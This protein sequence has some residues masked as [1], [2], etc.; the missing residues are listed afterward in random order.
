M[1]SVVELQ[2]NGHSLGPR[3][4]SVKHPLVLCHGFI[5]KR[6]DVA[7]VK[8]KKIDVQTVFRSR[9][10]FTPPFTVRVPE[11]HALLG[12]HTEDSLGLAIGVATEPWLH[13]AASPR[14]D[15]KI[16]IACHEQE[17]RA[18]FWMTRLLPQP[19][20]PWA[21]PII[22]MLAALRKREVMFSGFN[23]AVLPPFTADDV[24]ASPPALCAGTAL[25]IRELQPYRVTPSGLMRPPD[26]DKKNQLP[27]LLDFERQEIA[28][29]CRNACERLGLRGVGA[30][31]VAT[32]LNTKE[33]H[34]VST[35]FLH[36]TSRPVVLAGSM[37]LAV[38]D[39]GEPSRVPKGW[40]ADFNETCAAAARKM[41][42]RTLR[43]VDREWLE[44]HRERL[45]KKEYGCSRFVIEET[46]RAVYAEKALDQNDPLQF[47]NY[48]FQAQES[49][50][51]LLG[52]ST[53]RSDLMYQLARSHPACFGARSA[54]IG[55]G[56]P[57][58]CLLEFNGAKD[59]VGSISKLYRDLTGIETKP[60][61]R[62]FTGATD[63]MKNRW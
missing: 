60:I 26:R 20:A 31:T 37:V 28:R 36:G 9:F 53:A 52:N 49:A 63:S 17:E 61:I 56:G 1:R 23:L 14:T 44:D 55:F 16:E 13:M 21:D 51:E 4:L 33:Y 12:Q 35:D 6:P 39:T 41:K 3:R 57:V 11:A 30:V 19:K 8:P 34:V 58:A 42:G 47:G 25:I 15:G 32:S 24:P 38:C 18:S 54:G 48:L 27:P 45:T 62:P 43:S 10:G 2:V 22:E 40:L 29:L 46:M 7:A 59:F 5:L 50:R